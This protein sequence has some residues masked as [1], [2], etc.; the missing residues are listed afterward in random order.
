MKTGL[1]FKLVVAIVIA[2]VVLAITGPAQASHSSTAPA[3][4]TA[5]R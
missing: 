5:T 1:S 3:P 4:T 2:G